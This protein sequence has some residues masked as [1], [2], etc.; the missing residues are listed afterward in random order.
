MKCYC[1]SSGRLKRIGDISGIDGESV[2]E[3]L[4]EYQILLKAL[5]NNMEL[6]NQGLI[7]LEKHNMIYQS[8]EHQYSGNNRCFHFIQ[9]IRLNEKERLQ[10]EGCNGMI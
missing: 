7:F 9:W 5:S 8:F 2:P 6:M 3:D 10:I 4:E 1:H